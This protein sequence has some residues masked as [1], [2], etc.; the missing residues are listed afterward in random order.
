MPDNNDALEQ[1]YA[2][3][4]EDKQRKRDYHRDYNARN[5]EYKRAHKKKFRLGKKLKAVSYLG[6]RCIDCKQTYHH[7]MYHFHHVEPLKK[8]SEIATMIVNNV[9]WDRIQL[10]LD[11]CVLLCAI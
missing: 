4:E 5:R 7:C 11:K 3:L 10:E 6:D 1:L 2:L 8:Q 9:S